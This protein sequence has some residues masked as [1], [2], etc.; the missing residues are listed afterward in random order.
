MRY[1]TKEV[2]DGKLDGEIVWI[3]HYHRPYL[4]KKPLRNVPPTKV[5]IRPLS[6]LPENKTVYY[7]HSFFSP[8]QGRKTHVAYHIPC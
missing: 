7:S 5:L 3:C 6:D 4:R 8:E 1:D 2:R